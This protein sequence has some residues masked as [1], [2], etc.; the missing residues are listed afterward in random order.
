MTGIHIFKQLSIAWQ[1]LKFKVKN[2]AHINTSVIIQV[3]EVNFKKYFKLIKN[4]SFS[5]LEKHFYLLFSIKKFLIM[6]EIYTVDKVIP[7]I[8][9]TWI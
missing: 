5:S 8:K 4:Y 2:F 9:P 1:F 3:F 7:Y 6:P